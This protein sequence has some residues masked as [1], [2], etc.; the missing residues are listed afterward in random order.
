MGTIEPG[1]AVKQSCA[2]EQPCSHLRVVH[3]W[4]FG[5]YMGRKRMRK[6]Y[7]FLCVLMTVSLWS[8]F[9]GTGNSQDLKI[10]DAFREVAKNVSPA[11][12][13]L[14]YEQAIGEKET[15][16]SG[17]IISPG[18]Y[19]ITTNHTIEMVENIIVILPDKREFKAIRIGADPKTDIA[20]L[21]IEGENLPVV[22]LGDSDVIEIGDWGLAL[23]G[24]FDQ[25]QPLTIGQ[26]SGIPRAGVTLLDLDDF[27][28]V[29]MS[30]RR[31]HGGGPLI[32]MQGE[33]IGFNAALGRQ[34]T[35]FQ[36][37]GFAIPSN[38]AKW[39]AERLITQGKIARGTIGIVMQPLTPEIAAAFGL[40][41]ITGVIIGD[42][43]SG[44]PAEKAGITRGD[45]LIS[46]DGQIIDSPDTV[47]RLVATLDIGKQIPLVIIRDGQEKT[48]Q[49]VIEEQ[50]TDQ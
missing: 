26:I 1:I 49:M 30:F 19:V 8:I 37:T 7:G 35:E 11:V 38:L 16:G 23:G 5:T 43:L 32:N 40:E 24:D 14:C 34:G 31:E 36:G 46:I 12:V 22:S 15:F 44:S 18:G 6:R 29:E 28:H 47:R 9:P 50:A 39:V 17:S 3:T 27:I 41:D 33:V 4:L 20:V 48:I 2:C 10:N 13:L 42:T 45:I 21:Q 25:S